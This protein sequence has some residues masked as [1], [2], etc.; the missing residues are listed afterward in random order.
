MPA[1]RSTL[2]VGE[3]NFSFGAAVCGRREPGSR[4]T[5]TCLQLREEALRHEGA[6]GNIRAIQDSGGTVLFQVDCTNLQDCASLRGQVFDL[7]V[8]NFP[9]CGRKSGVKKNRELLKLFFLSCVQVLAEDGE[10]HVSLCNGQGGTPADQP[11]REWHNSWQVVAMAAEAHLILSAVK[12]FEK[13]T[14]HSYKCTGYRSQDKGFHVEKALLHVFTRSPPY[15]A[16]Q[17]VQVEEVVG[18]KNVHYSIP[19]ELSDYVF[20]KFNSADSLHPVKLV[21]DYLLEGLGWPISMMTE[22]VPF[23]ITARQLQRCCCGVDASRCFQIHPLQK[24]LPPDA[25][26][27]GGPSEG[28]EDVDATRLSLDK[29]DNVKS[30][31]PESSRPAC[32]SEADPEV[33][34]AHYW[35]RPSLLPQ[36]EELVAKKEMINKSND[37]SHQVGG[38]EEEEACDG[39]E[40]VLYG[41]SG[42][43]F[44]NEPI[45]LWA[46]PAFHELLI[47]GVFPPENETIKLL[48][49][50]LE[51]LFAP[52]GVSVV[53]EEGGLHLTAQ[54]IGLFGKVFTSKGADSHVGVTL[55]VN[56]DLLAALL[57][58]LPDWR[59]LWSHDPRVL[60]QFS[61]RPPPGTPFTPFSLFPEPVSFDISF[62]TGPAWEEKAFLAAVREAGRGTVEQ[63]QLIDAF[64]HP[65]L[66]QTSYCYRLVYH[67]H[68]HALPHTRA[69]QFHKH[70]ESLLSSRLQVTIR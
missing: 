28:R 70:L 33:E 50:K 49:E 42:V 4:V 37:A 52:Y 41:I 31:R 66:S 45:G 26:E 8:F 58:S 30:N 56:L 14:L 64:S 55:S 23:I 20:R 24:N 29:G 48:G 5:A 62:W 47:K 59:L 39:V 2:L 32:S 6:P 3:G 25:E 44:R 9:H 34:S 69:L 12:P 40:S 63:V 16:A 67:S 54:P 10:V 36:M 46:P 57:F 11:R 21:Q 17:V 43:V 60:K 13:E 65:D 51:A 1:P 35:L 38:N 53:T 18:G 15:T 7:V 61:R 68:T 22:S 19:A 27:V